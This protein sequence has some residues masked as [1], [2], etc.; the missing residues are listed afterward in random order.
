M[1]SFTD[2]SQTNQ[3]PRIL[4]VRLSAIGDVVQGMPVACALRAA[5]PKAHLAWC[6]Q[7]AGGTL[8]EGHPALDEVIIVDRRWMKS[9]RGWLALRK[10]LRDKKFD[11][12]IDSQSLNKSALIGWL[13][14]ARRRIG[15]GRPWGREFSRWLNNETVDT[16]PDCHM[17]KRNLKLLEPLGID[18][19]EVRFN[20]PTF[21]A[22]QK[23]IDAHLTSS[24]LD[25]PFALINVGAGWPSKLW[26]MD[27]FAE[28]ARYLGTRHQLP[29]VVVWAGEEERQMAETVIAQSDGHARLAPPTSLQELAELARRA[30]LFIGSDTGPLHLAAAIGTPCVGLYGP[31]P[32]DLHGPYGSEHISIQKLRFDGP[33]HLRRRASS[34][35]MNAIDVESVCEACDKQREEK[36]KN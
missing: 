16:P 9:A 12:T 20:V 4:L 23:T 24:G 30:S 25:G 29:V 2:S 15:L 13:S 17:V 32:A 33:S 26:P 18:N 31:W 21:A 1:S 22:A 8:L 11:I 35:Y 28:V 5:F 27:R 19:P 36:K 7:A 3:S 14:G 10:Q 6:V 34:E